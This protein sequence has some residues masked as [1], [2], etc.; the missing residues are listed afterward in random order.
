MET[1]AMASSWK[2]RFPGIGLII[3]GI[4]FLLPNITPIRMEHLWPLFVLTPGI[5]FVFLY[6]SDRTNVGLLM[7]ASIL[8]I[9]SLIFFTCA[10]SGW[11]LMVDLWPLF[12]MAPGIGFLLMYF[13]GTHE[14]GFLIPGIVLLVVG[15][16]FAASATDFVPFWPILMIVFG[17]FI[18]L[19]RR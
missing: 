8:I 14:R 5:Y 3:L 10:F 13:F 11:H 4:V 15:F 1:S 7:P 12:I 17:L 18:I 9:I 6:L 16:S 2:S 19:R